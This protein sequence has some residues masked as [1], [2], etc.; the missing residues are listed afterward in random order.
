[1]NFLDDNWT[2]ITIIPLLICSIIS[3]TL[4]IERLYFFLTRNQLTLKQKEQII[5]KAETG[6]LDD[7]EVMINHINPFFH[8]AFYELIRHRDKQKTFRDEVVTLSVNRTSRLLSQ[9]LTP[10]ATIGGLAPMLGL[11]G[12][13][14]GLMRSF[15]DIGLSTGPVEPSIVADGLWQALS[16][17][18]AG[19]VI[20]VICVFFNTY[21]RSKAREHVNDVSDILSHLSLLLEGRKST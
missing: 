17:T 1:M 9:R 8:D 3:L 12:T 2:T 21:F 16:T 13:I 6:N 10:I 18:A 20:A 11:L 19:M 4:I 7:A 15:Y 5:I 14:I